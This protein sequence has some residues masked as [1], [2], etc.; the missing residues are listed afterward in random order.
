MSRAVVARR[1]ALVL[2]L[3]SGS[4]L[5]IASPALADW[6]SSISFVG[7]PVT[8]A[9]ESE[10]HAK[11]ELSLSDGSNGYSLPVPPSGGSVD[12]YLS[13][14]QAPWA[15]GLPI[16]SDGTVYVSQPLAQPLLPAGEYTLSAAFVPGPDSGLAPARTASSLLV[17]ITSLTVTPTLSVSS[18]PATGEWVMSADL[19]GGYVDAYGAPPGT[20]H[21]AV[22]GAGGKVAFETETAVDAGSIAGITIPVDAKLTP[23]T[24]YTIT[25]SFE[26]AAEIAPGVT[27]ADVAPVEFTAEGSAP[28]SVVLIPSWAAIALLG[29]V[30]ALA[31]ASIVLGMR[32]RARM[33]RGASPT[34]EENHEPSDPAVLGS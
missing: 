2:A 18:D 12:I 34:T 7:E 3:G 11:L 10:W 23:G 13:G 28:G 1:V 25:A 16:Q 24:D 27:V 9:F 5:L 33:V 14:L 19:A 32:V 22:A 6:S 4:A 26:P 8:A 17:T 30:V 21:V 29:V 15:T 31:V 20:W